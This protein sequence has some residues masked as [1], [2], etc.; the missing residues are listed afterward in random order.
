MFLR[1][2]R[3]FLKKKKRFDLSKDRWCKIQIMYKRIS[4]KILQRICFEERIVGNLRCWWIIIII[5]LKKENK[6]KK[7][8]NIS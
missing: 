5:D 4:N 1:R 6:R 3:L 7:K 8:L 2:R